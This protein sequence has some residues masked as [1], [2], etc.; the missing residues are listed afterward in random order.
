MIGPVGRSGAEA[1]RDAPRNPDA[2]PTTP[3][4]QTTLRVLSDQNRAATGGMMSIATIRIRP[5]SFSP[6]T[7]TAMVS[8]IM[9]RS[10]RATE[11]PTEAAKPGSKATKVMGRRSAITSAST[12]KPAAAMNTASWNSIPAVAPSRNSSS[13]A[14]RPVVMAWMTVSS[15]MPPPKKTESTAPMAASSAS[16]V[17]REI[18]CTVTRPSQALNADPASR[19]GRLRPS[20]PSATRTMKATPT[21]GR[22]ACATASES[23]ARLRRNMKVPV[24]PAA[25]PSRVV[26]TV[27]SAA[28]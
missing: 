14:R 23:S 28:L 15:T 25:I 20:P 3:A 18:H 8:A 11:I 6:T 1:D 24:L 2:P 26:P 27:T 19:A 16:R 4:I 9:A 5:T 17:R 13:P 10:V 22:V 7:V 12:S 21:P